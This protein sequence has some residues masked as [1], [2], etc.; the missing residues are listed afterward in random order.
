MKSVGVSAVVP[1]VDVPPSDAEDIQE[2]RL[3]YWHKDNETGRVLERYEL[4]HNDQLRVQWRLKDR[5][6]RVNFTEEYPF[7]QLSEF[8][9]QYGDQQ[10]GV[11]IRFYSPP[12]DR[13]ELGHTYLST[14][15]EHVYHQ[16]IRGETA[17]LYR[18]HIETSDYTRIQ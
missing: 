6:G 8:Y 1:Y 17:H 12:P 10:Y 11:V 18:E 9:Q 7:D 15:G 16:H 14:E 4:T 3:T 2:P 13:E 5:K